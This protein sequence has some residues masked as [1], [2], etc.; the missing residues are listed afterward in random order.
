MVWAPFP[1]APE[2]GVTLDH[3]HKD[4][5]IQAAFNTGGDRF[6]TASYD[7]TVKVWDTA[8]QE[9]I[10]V[11]KGHEDEPIKAD[12]SPDGRHVAS[13]SRLGTVRVWNIET[14]E[15]VFRQ[16]SSS[17]HFSES[18]SPRYGSR[19]RLL[20]EFITGL[21]PSPF[22]RRG[23]KLVNYDGA[24]M[25][26]HDTRDWTTL[27]KLISDTNAGWP[28]ISP[29][30]G[31]VAKLTDKLDYI[32]V[33][34]LDT[35][36]KRYSLKGHDSGKQVFWAEFSND[37]SQIVTCAMDKTAIVWDAGDGTKLARMEGHTSWLTQARFSPGGDRIATASADGTAKIWDTETGNHLSTLSN[38]TGRR[39]R[40]SNVEFNPDP[41]VL[42]VLTTSTDDTIRIWAPDGAVARE[43]LQITRDSKL[44]YATWSPDGRRIL[45]CWKDG[46]V[47]LY[48]TIPWGHLA[49]IGDDSV[50]MQERI[51]EWRASQ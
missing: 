11:F 44:I 27:H 35:G 42:R 28:V 45:S 32:D 29:S 12:F 24:Q 13:V 22:A 9:L 33:W 21:S 47:R 4:I 2:S 1:L 41:E 6:V 8:S 51:S 10:S 31:L 39:R 7:K 30:G 14:L 49:A 15:E 3:A 26:V 25:V 19:G 40:I 5:V 16:E 36:A 38:S 17:N 46:V 20:L 37:S 48:G 50:E 18:A 43:L 34:D 23:S